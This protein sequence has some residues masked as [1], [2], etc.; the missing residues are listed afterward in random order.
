VIGD[1]NVVTTP[2]G[3]PISAQ[4]Q[5]TQV[6]WLGTLLS[7]VYTAGLTDATPTE[8]VAPTVDGAQ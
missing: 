2:D 6:D 3:L 4:I 5:T 8:L 1:T 7:S